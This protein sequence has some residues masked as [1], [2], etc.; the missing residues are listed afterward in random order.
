MQFFCENDAVFLF[1][2]ALENVFRNLESKNSITAPTNTYHELINTIIT[3]WTSR[4]VNDDSY[5][6]GLVSELVTC[7]CAA[8]YQATVAATLL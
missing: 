3:G 2:C 8:V 5:N 6:S 7:A 1:S 4:W